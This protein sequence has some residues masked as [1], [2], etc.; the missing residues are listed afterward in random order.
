[1]P[2]RKEI[3]NVQ[4]MGTSQWTPQPFNPPMHVLGVY[5]QEGARGT[6]RRQVLEEVDIDYSDIPSAVASLTAFDAQNDK[7]IITVDTEEDYGS[8]RT[9]VHLR[10]WRDATDEEVGWVKQVLAHEKARHEEGKQKQIEHAREVLRK[11]GELP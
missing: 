11:A 1:M 2:S 9:R 4:V 6:W 3:R 5:E 8:T 7:A 10:G